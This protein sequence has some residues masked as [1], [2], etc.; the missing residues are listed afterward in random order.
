MTHNMHKIKNLSSNIYR[1]GF[2][3][4]ADSV[5]ATCGELNGG[6]SRKQNSPDEKMHIKLRSLGLPLSRHCSNGTTATGDAH[7]AKLI[8]RYVTRLQVA[9]FSK[10]LSAS[11]L[12][13]DT[14]L[15]LSSPV[16]SSLPSLPPSGSVFSPLDGAHRASRH[17]GMGLTEKRAN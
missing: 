17:R 1:L 5:A 15:R 4:G 8:S 10:N 14:I 12:P 2:G 16:A 11:T 3:G 7:Y 9:A 6:T 13:L